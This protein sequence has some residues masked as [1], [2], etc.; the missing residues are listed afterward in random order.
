MRTD[1]RIESKQI[2]TSQFSS[3]TRLHRACE[4]H[5]I[6]LELLLIFETNAKIFWYFDAFARR[7]LFFVFLFLSF[8]FHIRRDEEIMRSLW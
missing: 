4:F 3:E 5:L 7:R 8:S 1:Y 2:Q 6:T